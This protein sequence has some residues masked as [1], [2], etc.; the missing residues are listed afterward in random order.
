M[1][2]SKKEDQDANQ[3][4][5]LDR[6]SKNWQRWRSLILTLIF[7]TLVVF[8]I[9]GAAITYDNKNPDNLR[10]NCR[11]SDQ[12]ICQKRAQST[13]FSQDYLKNYHSHWANCWVVVEKVV[14]DLSQ[15]RQ[16]AYQAGSLKSKIKP[17]CGGD[18][19]Q[20]LADQ[21]PGNEFIIGKI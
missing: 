10:Q 17:Y 21:P 14:Y 11:L 18:A 8:V 6:F 2:K 1:A 12:P 5:L 3:G 9:I 20:L 19:S 16:P 15:G 4:I 13:T 7:L